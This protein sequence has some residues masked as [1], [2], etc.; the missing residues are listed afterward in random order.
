MGDA[1]GCTGDERFGVVRSGTVALEEPLGWPD[2]S[3]VAVRLAPEQ[4]S[5]PGRD[6]GPVII[7]GYGLAG[8]CVADLLEQGGIP[9]VVV[10]RN[11]ATVRTQR[12]LGRRV[13]EGDISE[14]R[15]LVAARVA[16][17]SVLALTIP[18]EDAVL[19]AT[20]TARRLNPD[21]Y[22]IARTTYAS[23][24]MRAAQLGANE[25]IKSEQAVA[26]LFYEKM[27]QRLIGSA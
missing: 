26:M 15:T 6:A 12:D 13:V 9:Y 7:A 23:R 10:E 4:A 25:V 11:V 1:G 20:S 17:A 3:R 14:E 2:G 18:D 19:R 8:R 27:R 5:T 22:I 16:S 24:G 21:L